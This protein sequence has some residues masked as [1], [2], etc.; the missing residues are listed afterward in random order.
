MPAQVGRLAG[1]Q[2]LVAILQPVGIEAR[3]L[4]QLLHRADLPRVRREAHKLSL[5]SEQSQCRALGDKLHRRLAI[6]HP[7][8]V[9]RDGSAAELP[10]SEPKSKPEPEPKPHAGNLP[11]QEMSFARG[12]EIVGSALHKREQTTSDA[13]R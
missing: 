3:P 6:A 11:P 1:G 5:A 8:R 10:E 13:A 12:A 9:R 2:H 7:H 4:I